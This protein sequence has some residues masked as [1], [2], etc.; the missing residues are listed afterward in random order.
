M[1]ITAGHMAG[2]VLSTL[3]VLMVTGAGPR[4]TRRTATASRRWWLPAS[5]LFGASWP[6]LADRQ[7]AREALKG[8]ADVDLPIVLDGAD[9][10]VINEAQWLS[11]ESAYRKGWPLLLLQPTTEQIETVIAKLRIE[12]DVPEEIADLD[13]IGFES[14]AQGDIEAVFEYI[15]SDADRDTET[16]VSAIGEWV[17][18]KQSGGGSRCSTA[19]SRRSTS[20]APFRGP[21]PRRS[22]NR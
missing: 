4:T 15:N 16:R 10:S 20:S 3:C 17:A 1:R 22:W 7:F 6:P 9:I 21:A 2:T 14:T 18:E 11:I 12:L 8:N 19:S 5:V 13:A